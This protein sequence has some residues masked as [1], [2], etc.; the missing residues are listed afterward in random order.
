MFKGIQQFCHSIRESFY[1]R[2]GPYHVFKG[3]DISDISMNG[4]LI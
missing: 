1:V 2:C 3:E 4:I